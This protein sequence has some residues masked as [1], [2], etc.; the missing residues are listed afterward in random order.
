MGFRLS[1]NGTP[2]SNNGTLVIGNH[3]SYL[4]ILIYLSFFE[5]LFVTSIETK[6]KLFLGQITSLAG[7]LFVE[8][9]NPRN[10]PNELKTIKKYFDNNLSVCIFPEGTSSNGERILPFKKSLFQLPLETKC[11]IQPIVLNYTS[12]DGKDF[13][14]K[15]CDLVC[16]HGDHQPFFK[17]LL[18]LLTLKKIEASIEIL[19]Q[20]DS[21]QF[22][23]RKEIAD[24][25]Y[26]I[27]ADNYSSSRSNF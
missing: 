23:N 14:S 5:C 25:C 16:W 1:L 12:I 20:I 26:K 22:E 24:Y 8:R 21:S 11:P 4:D 17:H 10:L 13:S 6:E 2:P 18:T 7:C 3:M 19:P 15:T 27:L 9:R